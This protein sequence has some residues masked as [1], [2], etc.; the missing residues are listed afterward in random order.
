[1]LWNN[2]NQ[3]PQKTLGSG[4]IT[5]PTLRRKPGIKPRVQ[6]GSATLQD[7]YPSDL[8]TELW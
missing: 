4:Q 6:L 3:S 5:Y 8:A 7:P 1:M 2:F